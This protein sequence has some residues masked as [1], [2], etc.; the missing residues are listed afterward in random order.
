MKEMKKLKFVFMVLLVLL[1]TS[2]KAQDMQ[3]LVLDLT[4][5]SQ[6][7]IALADQPVITLQG[8][9]HLPA[10]NLTGV[11]SVAFTLFEQI[12]KLL[13]VKLFTS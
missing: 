12:V 6:T 10:R 11:G 5:G 2:V 13:Y 4:D 8:E 7:V 3:Y 9:E 1:A